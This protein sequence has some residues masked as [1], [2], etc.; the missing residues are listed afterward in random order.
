MFLGLLNLYLYSY[1]LDTPSAYLLVSH[2]S[3]DSRPHL[4]IAI[5]RKLVQQRLP[6][7]AN[8]PLL[9]GDRGNCDEST[10]LANCDESVSRPFHRPP[11]ATA[12]LDCSPQPLH[13]QICYFAAEVRPQGI[14]QIQILPLF[15]LPGV[16]VKQ[17]IPAQLAIA[18]HR[19]G[20]TVEL[21][22]C[23]FLGSHIGLPSLVADRLVA[24][25]ADAHILLSHGSRRTGG[26]APVE[27]LAQQL[28]ATAAYWSVAP[29]LATQV[30]TLMAKGAQQLAI[31]PY[32]MFPGS[33]GDAI[34]QQ[35]AQLTQQLPHLQLTLMSPLAP[36][37]ELAQLVAE[38]TRA[39][40][41]AEVTVRADQLH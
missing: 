31:F 22:L 37:W 16:H 29:S 9:A 28:G 6:V 19:L 1:S 7:P 13:E 10:F 8:V 32:F 17:D 12:V 18:Q 15:L 20:L 4:A 11:V 40:S 23:P 24:Q 3:H 35:I 21:L 38:L 41:S 27:A 39:S 34:A 5:L 26:N 25:S 33:I 14:R 30:Q 36:N 2:G